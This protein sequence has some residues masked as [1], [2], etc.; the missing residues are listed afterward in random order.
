[1]FFFFLDETNAES[2]VQNISEPIS[3]GML[4]VYIFYLFIFCYHFI[5]FSDNSEDSNSLDNME[6]S[7]QEPLVEDME[8]DSIV[9]AMDSEASV[10]RNRR[11]AFFESRTS[12]IGSYRISS[13]SNKNKIVKF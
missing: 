6:N 3:T 8:M 12:D 4:S 13:D 7:S 11:L 9:N 10:L 5:Q 1:M 2:S